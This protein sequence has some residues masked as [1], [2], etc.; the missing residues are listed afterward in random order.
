MSTHVSYSEVGL[1]TQTAHPWLPLLLLT[2]DDTRLDVYV[3]SWVTQKWLW[4]TCGPLLQPVPHRTLQVWLV[5]DCPRAA[6]VDPW[7][8]ASLVRPRPGGP[9]APHSPPKTLRESAV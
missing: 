8:S 2:P 1:W 6:L 9:P 5:D 3:P 7:G 4:R